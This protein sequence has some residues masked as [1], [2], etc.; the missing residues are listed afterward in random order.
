MSCPPCA[1]TEGR[2]LSPV[3]A[4]AWAGIVLLLGQVEPGC[5]APERRV[6]DPGAEG[7]LREGAAGTVGT[8]VAPLPPVDPGGGSPPGALLAGEALP[9]G[10]EPAAA[11][12]DP[13]P[14]VCPVQPERSL[15][16]PFLDAGDAQGSVSVGTVADGYLVNGAALPDP[17]PG[18][19]VLPRQA[20]RC[21]RYG[22]DELIGVLLRTA[23]RVGREYPGARLYLG[24]LSAPGGGDIV[25]SMSHNSGRD[26][27]IAFL[28]TDAEG[29][30]V[31]PTDL[32]FFDSH[33]WSFDAQG[34]YRLDLERTWAIIRALLEDRQVT[35]QYIFI[36][37]PLKRKLLEH[38]RR[39]GERGELLA[40][41]EQRLVQPGISLHN[42][43][44]HL[45][46]H[47]SAA[48]IRLGCRELGP[49]REGAPDP[50]PLVRKEVR[51]ILPLLGDPDE[52]RRYRA[53]QLLAVLGDG[54]AVPGLTR[55]L[56]DPVAA[57]RWQALR[58]LVEL[59]AASAVGPILELLKHEQDASCVLA[60]L[61]A[62]DRLGGPRAE[63]G[64]ARL[65]ADGRA[66]PAS[67]LTSYEPPWPRPAPEQEAGPAPPAATGA[68]G[69]I[70]DLA[71]PDGPTDSGSETLLLR[72]E[73]ARALA[74]ATSPRV[75]PP[76]LALL[77]DPDP[78]AAAA[79]RHALTRL[80]NRDEGADPAAWKR[81][82]AANRQK[83]R[84]RWVADGFRSAG[85]VVPEKPRLAD[86]PVLLAAV[87][88]APEVSC[89]ARRLLQ[90][91][92]H[93]APPR[94]LEWP[95]DDAALYWS[96]RWRSLG[97]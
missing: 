30:P 16:F 34:A 22:T 78:R 55:L 76:L 57:V 31:E 8:V 43:H 84:E 69:D 21:L 4:V 95:A 83:S 2:A 61:A 82:W 46:L 53:A 86:V 44:L 85:F 25:W 70:V 38:A 50:A 42:D 81:W 80:T 3:A 37:A 72:A 92:L 74:G 39:R 64:L 41:A 90:S 51:R 73:A 58:A 56:R 75:V 62:L 29:V 96:R 60:A 65:T 88:A 35:V 13:A 7:G 89:N 63:Q 36:Y 52:A 5:A 17:C 54:A 14:P 93:R 1:V 24:N 19:V 9:A 49:R 94:Q 40:A 68:G 27:D 59:K 28:M 23:E 10:L 48:D 47:C 71:G 12:E 18:C 91:L 45:R 6:A 87:K 77:E 66:F 26:V 11:P 32:M 97:H 79:A 67:V 20:A 15:T 33:G